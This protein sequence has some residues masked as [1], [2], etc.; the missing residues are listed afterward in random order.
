MNDVPS[1]IRMTSRQR[2]QIRSAR[3]AH[4]HN[5]G[6]LRNFKIT[7]HDR[8]V[9]EDPRSAVLPGKHTALIRQIHSGTIDQINDRHAVS[10]RD[11]LRTQNLFDR[12]GI[13]RTGLDRRVIRNDD[14]FA[15]LNFSDNRYD[16]RR[17]CLAVVLVIGD[18]QSDLLRESV[19]IEK[20]SDPFTGRQLSLFVDLSDFLRAA[21]ELEFVLETLEI[22]SPGGYEGGKFFWLGSFNGYVSDA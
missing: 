14:A 15:V 9:I 4:P 2:R 7:P 10:H 3:D 17:R 21:A 6:D 16:R 18:K 19:F 5:G 12:L 1:T 20:Q 11:L 22:R 8:V 13:P